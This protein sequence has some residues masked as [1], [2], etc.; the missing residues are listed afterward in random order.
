[1][2]STHDINTP[3]D[4]QDPFLLRRSEAAA[5]LSISTRKLW[6]LTNRGEIP[7]VRIDSAVR[8]DPRDIEAWIKG[9]KEKSA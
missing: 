3:D 8:Y 1:M 5:M 2:K 6:E 4:P 7:C 9:K